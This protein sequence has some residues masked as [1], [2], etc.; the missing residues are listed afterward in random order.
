M[1][2]WSEGV[3]PWTAIGGALMLLFAA[4]VVLLGVWFLSRSARTPQVGTV[5]WPQSGNVT[6]GERSPKRNL[7]GSRRT[8]HSLF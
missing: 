6:R 4:G 5:L 7:T 2:Y 3:G 8:C 1:C